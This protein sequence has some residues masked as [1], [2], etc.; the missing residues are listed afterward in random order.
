[1]SKRK[2]NKAVLAVVLVMVFAVIAI[3]YGYLAPSLSGLTGQ[4]LAGQTESSPSSPSSGPEIK[5]TSKSWVNMQLDFSGQKLI[6][7]YLDGGVWYDIE[8]EMNNPVNFATFDPAACQ[9]WKDTG[10][11]QTSL[12]ST[13]ESGYQ[14]EFGAKYVTEDGN[15]GTYCFVF[16]SKDGRNVRGSFTVEETQR[17]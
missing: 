4:P 7:Q 10:K 12:A 8:F 16:K 6:E 17:L 9:R 14:E 15:D 3:G 13:G 11:F 1:M 5:V 2:S